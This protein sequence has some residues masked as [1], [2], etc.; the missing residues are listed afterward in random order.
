MISAGDIVSHTVMCL[1]ER[2]SLQK[3]MNF[4]SN[5]ETSVIL[6][7]RRRDAPY[8]DRIE[9]D[10]RVLIYEG[11]DVS[12]LRGGPDPKAVDQPEQSGTGRYTENGR[13]HEAAV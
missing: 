2:M 9:Q 8:E 5:E 3:G 11:H 1:N 10:G 4:R 12:R 13:F 7:S 6:M